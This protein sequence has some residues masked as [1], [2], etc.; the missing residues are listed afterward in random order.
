MELRGR[1]ASLTRSKRE[2][3]QVQ[4]SSFYLLAVTNNTYWILGMGNREKRQPLLIGAQKLAEKSE[5]VKRL[6]E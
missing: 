5:S 2:M 6:S 3:V 1:E 4:H